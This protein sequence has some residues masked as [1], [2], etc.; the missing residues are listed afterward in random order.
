MMHAQVMEFETVSHYHYTPYYRN[1]NTHTLANKSNEMVEI[2]LKR[3]MEMGKDVP[4]QPTCFL[5]VTCCRVVRWCLQYRFHCN[6]RFVRIPFHSYNFRTFST[7]R[8]TCNESGNQNQPILAGLLF[9]KALQTNVRFRLHFAMV[10]KNNR[11]RWLMVRRFQFSKI[12]YGTFNVKSL[13][14]QKQ[15]CVKT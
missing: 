6:S 4:L 11:I 8:T 15:R 10:E 7:F 2:H 5:Q 1:T 12:M 9:S 14:E 3:G 13:F